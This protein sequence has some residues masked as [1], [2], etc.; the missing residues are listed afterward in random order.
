MCVCVSVHMCVCL[1]TCVCVCAHA[2]WLVGQVRNGEERKT[3][4]APWAQALAKPHLLR[5][6]SSC[7]A[8]SRT[9]SVP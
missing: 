3:L 7:P 6:P 8:F 9:S 1:C 4:E 2:W 5:L